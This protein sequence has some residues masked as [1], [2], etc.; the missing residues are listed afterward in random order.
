MEIVETPFD[1]C[2]LLK[3]TVFKDARGYFFES[4]NQ[5]KFENLTGWNSGFV[6][7]N[8][9]E[10]VYGVVRGLHFQVGDFAQAK[11]VRVLHGRV[12]DVVLD[13]RPESRTFGQ[14]YSVELT[15]EN[16]LQVFI[17][18]GFAHGFS[19]LSEK[20]TFFYKCDNY[21]QKGAEAGINPLDNFLNVNWGIPLDAITLSPKDMEAASWQAYLERTKIE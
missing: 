15:A 5:Q 1:G 8:Q 4:Y 6:Q 18:R 9:S 11:L 3:N 2:F 14:H 19:V 16:G 20:A 17:S 7:D 12:L 13:I 10:S 21:Y